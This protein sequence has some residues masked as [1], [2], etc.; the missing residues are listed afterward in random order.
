MRKFSPRTLLVVDLTTRKVIAERHENMNGGCS[1][2]KITKPI[3]EAVK[4]GKAIMYYAHRPDDIRIPVEINGRYFAKPSKWTPANVGC[5]PGGKASVVI[6]PQ[7]TPQVTPQVPKHPLDDASPT[8][9]KKIFH[10][11]GWGD[12]THH[13]KYDGAT[14]TLVRKDGTTRPM[15]SGAYPIKDVRRYISDG[16]WVVHP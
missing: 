10:H 9:V 2:A 6:A 3:Y 7:V 4:A 8:N 11:I 14:L 12:E 15:S 16:S 1:C 13:I 5:K